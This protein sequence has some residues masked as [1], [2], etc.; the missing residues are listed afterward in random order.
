MVKIYFT[1]LSIWPP[2]NYVGLFP[3]EN[4]HLRVFVLVAKIYSWTMG[5]VLNDRVKWKIGGNLVGWLFGDYREVLAD[6]ELL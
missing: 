2:Q 5:R 6:Y 1:I 4:R 3:E